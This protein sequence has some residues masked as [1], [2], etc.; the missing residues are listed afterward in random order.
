M[1]R[2]RMGLLI[3]SL[4]LWAQAHNKVAARNDHLYKAAPVAE[5]KALSPAEYKSISQDMVIAPDGSINIVWIQG[6]APVA[7]AVEHDHS[8]HGAGA[9]AMPKPSG[10]D[11]YFTRSTDSGR[12]FSK[13]VRVNDAPGIARGV[14]SNTPKL[15]ISKSGTIHVVYSANR[16]RDPGDKPQVMDLHYSRST[17][18]GASFEA[19]RP[20]N[21]DTDRQDYGFVAMGNAASHAFTSIAIA[22]DGTLHAFWIDTRYMKSGNDANALYTAT[23]RDDGKTFSRER[24]LFRDGI[25]ACCQTD[26]AVAA[27]GAMYLS[28]RHVYANGARETIVAKSADNGKTWSAPVRLT[29]KDWII[30]A[31]PHKPGSLALDKQGRIY[32][33]WYT[34]AE[35]P[36]GAYF[37]VSS[38]GGKTFAAPQPLHPN[39]KIWDHAQV[40][41]APDNSVRLVWDAKVGEARKLYTR[42]S[43]DQGKTLGAISE[44]ETP[45]GNA[46]FPLLAFAANGA[47]YLTWQ[48]NNQVM[49]RAM[50]AMV[51]QK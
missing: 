17:D 47:S 3:V 9:M 37:T 49:F 48:Q 39:A 14:N 7:Q 12:T 26:I 1:R 50:P 38:D 4:L 20:L 23:S 8:Q 51:A 25:C 34:E 43:T 19:A 2:I 32:A 18:R 15:A 45:A 44:I 22:L 31:C 21:N 11:L 40:A 41:V 36:G 27:N 42:V 28:W 16:Y 13:P 30:E 6:T 24:E 5:A 10:N 46:T 29:P 33:T 35:K